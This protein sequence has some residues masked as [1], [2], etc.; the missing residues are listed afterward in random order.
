M[1]ENKLTYLVIT[2]EEFKKSLKRFIK[3]KRFYS[4]PEQIENLINQLKI[5]NFTGD[6]LTINHSP[7]YKIY[8]KRLPNPDTNSG[9]LN[10]YR[11]IYIVVQENDTVGLLDIY[12]KKEEQTLTEE[13]IQGLI[14]GFLLELLPYED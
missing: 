7:E 10:G 6:I 2:V 1:N 8:K 11:V 5:G 13:Y 14:D 4:L 3:K 12:Y 9:T